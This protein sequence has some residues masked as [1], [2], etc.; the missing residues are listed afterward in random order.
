ME[1]ERWSTNRF[2]WQHLGTCT[3][4]VWS[5][6]PLIFESLRVHKISFVQHLP[7][8]I[9]DWNNVYEIC[10]KTFLEGTFMSCVLQVFLCALIPRLVCTRAQLRG[11]IGME[12]FR[13]CGLSDG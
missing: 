3:T 12:I 5:M 1:I 6:V 4:T 7:G 2:T 10:A 11:N 8:L 13:G 9:C